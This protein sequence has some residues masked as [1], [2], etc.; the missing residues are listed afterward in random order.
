MEAPRLELSHR[1]EQGIPVVDVAG[2]IDVYTFPRFKEH[3]SQINE[4]GHTHLLVTLEQVHYMDSSG[5]GALLGATKR[6]RPEGGTLGL[7]GSNQ[8]ITRMLKITRLNTIFDMFDS[9]NEAVEAYLQG[10][11]AASS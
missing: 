1:F 9:E 2:D 5:F 6:L 11:K 4:E 3:L 8:V 10:A 7:V